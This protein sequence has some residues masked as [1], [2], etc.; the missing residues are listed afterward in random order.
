[1][2]GQSLETAESIVHIAKKKKTK[3][4]KDIAKLEKQIEKKMEELKANKTKIKEDIKKKQKEIKELSEPKKKKKTIDPA[5]VEN[6]EERIF[7]ESR[8]RMK[9]L[10]TVY[11]AMK[12]AAV[13][14]QVLHEFHSGTGH[15][16]VKCAWS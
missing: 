1:M 14:C 10:L 4:A 2:L 16:G 3:V 15:A 12:E 13:D 5:S 6:I 7:K 8:E 9:E 11:Q